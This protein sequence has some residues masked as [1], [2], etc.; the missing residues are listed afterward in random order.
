M[1]TRHVTLWWLKDEVALVIYATSGKT[2]SSVCHWLRTLFYS[3]F[4][5]IKVPKARFALPPL[6]I[7]T[8]YSQCACAATHSNFDD[9]DFQQCENSPFQTRSTGIKNRN[10]NLTCVTLK[11]TSNFSVRVACIFFYLLEL[12]EACLHP[13]SS[14]RIVARRFN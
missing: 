13:S 11:M 8:T 7:Q 6:V 5:I 12:L 9:S 3:I 14:Q 1:E 10:V 2:I 4:F